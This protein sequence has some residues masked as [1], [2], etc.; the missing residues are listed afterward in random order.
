M[1]G[2]MDLAHSLFTDCHDVLDVL[3][4]CSNRL[5]VLLYRSSYVVLGKEKYF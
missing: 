4:S 3:I 2:W 1:D 5:L